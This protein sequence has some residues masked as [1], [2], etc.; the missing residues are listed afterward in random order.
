MNLQLTPKTGMLLV[1][2]I[3]HQPAKSESGLIQL[4]DVYHE[5]ETS[6]EIV[7][8]AERFICPDCG[9]GR[10]SE[11]SVGD[12]V[13]FPPSAGDELDWQGERYLIVPESA[14]LAVVCEATA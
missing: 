3:Q 4:A 14:V 11:L 6:G 5:P 9:A 7:A 1:K 10:A 2:P 13:V 12:V 8:M